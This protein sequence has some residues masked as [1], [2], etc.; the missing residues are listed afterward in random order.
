MF[1]S[2]FRLRWNA[3]FLF[4]L[5]SHGFLTVPVAMARPVT[6]KGGWSYYMAVLGAVTRN[7]P[8]SA[9]RLLSG[10]GKADLSTLPPLYRNRLAILRLW[11]FPPSTFSGKGLRHMNR[12]GRGIADVLFWHAMNEPAVPASRRPGLRRKFAHMY[13]FSPFA[14]GPGRS[15]RNTARA[16][17]QRSLVS[18]KEGDTLTAVSLWKK[19]V[20]RHPLSPE[21][22]LALM[23]LGTAGETGDV[24][25]PRWEALSS[26]GMGALASGE[27][28]HYL[29]LE[30]PF[31]YR[32]LATILRSVELARENH[33]FRARKLLSTL[34]QEKGPRLLASLEATRC[35]L[36]RRPEV[37]ESCIGDFLSRFPDS[38]DGRRLV[39][40]FL[41]Q[42]MALGK[43]MVPPGWKPPAV[44]MST[45][46]GQDSLWLYGLAA[47]LSGRRDAAK[48]AWEELEEDLST[49]KGT[50]AFAFRL[51]R[52]RYFLGRLSSLNGDKSEA[53]SFYKKVLSEAPETPYAMWATLACRSD[54]PPLDVR[55]H[56]PEKGHRHLTRSDRN[57]IL[58]LVQMGL[59]GPALLMTEM[60]L[61]GGHLGRRILRY[62]SLDMSVFPE[63][64]YRVI[65]EVIPLDPPGI[66]LAR[67]EKVN[68][69]V[70]RGVRRSGVDPEWAISIARQES[71]FM[72]KS[73]SIDGALG[74]MQLMPPTALSVAHSSGDPVYLTISRNLGKIRVPENNSYLGG[75]Y[76]RR[77]LEHYP[78][79]PERAV[80]S[81]NAGMHSVVRWKGLENQDWDFFVEGIPFRETRRYDREVLWNYLFIHRSHL[82]RKEG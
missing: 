4:L 17:W 10:M 60:R 48:N 12:T 47:F 15:G 28:K 11:Y 61:D 16:L 72:E 14:S 31:P 29:A 44:L 18:V 34:T 42:Q 56:R 1:F 7:D 2:R 25:I 67:A 30:P 9:R 43:G 6:E 8:V 82:L 22:G 23:R 41:R 65:Q 27:I 66:H 55:L 32:D 57:R 73:L 36:Y 49:E 50:S 46:P 79:N 21:S 63:E 78:K 54:C 35:Q 19:L 59:W 64:R 5:A 69:F 70:L 62:G 40:G 39:N 33:R 37:S 68:G 13:P 3:F 52:V 74:I 20:A 38:I 81:Y 58:T 24:L 26:M 45:G 51:A 53:R 71:R 76:L 80:A 77:L 75:L